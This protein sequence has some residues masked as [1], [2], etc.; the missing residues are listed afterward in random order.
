MKVHEQLQNYTCKL[1]LENCKKV[2][3]PEV[4]LSSYKMS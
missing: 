2:E 1:R 4:L 3:G